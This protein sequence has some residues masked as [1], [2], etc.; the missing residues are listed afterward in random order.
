MAKL[1]DVTGQSFRQSD[2]FF[3]KKQQG[4][5]IHLQQLVTAI[6]SAKNPQTGFS[7]NIM[8]FGREIFRHNP[9]LI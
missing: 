2:V 3:K 1:N 8:M 4:W 6:R 7:P 5:D 9:R